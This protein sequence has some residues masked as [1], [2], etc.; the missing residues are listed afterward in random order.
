VPADRGIAYDDDASDS[1]SRVG[2]NTMLKQEQRDPIPHILIGEAGRRLGLP[3]RRST[4]KSTR[5]FC[6]GSDS[7]IL[8]RQLGRVLLSR[9]L[10]RSSKTPRVPPSK[11]RNGRRWM[12]KRSLI[13][14]E[15][16]RS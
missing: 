12:S 3:T 4:R 13:P 8:V 11:R 5:V 9:Y 7:A 6:R 16:D 14:L 10:L 2:V 1:R 15:G